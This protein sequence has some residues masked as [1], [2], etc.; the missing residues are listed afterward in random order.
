MAKTPSITSDTDHPRKIITGT[1]TKIGEDFAV[2]RNT[3][4]PAKSRMASVATIATTTA[5]I[6]AGAVSSKV[7]IEMRKILAG[8]TIG[9]DIHEHTTCHPRKS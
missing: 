1:T 4:V 8:R 9:P 6:T 7:T 3:T 2:L 5:T